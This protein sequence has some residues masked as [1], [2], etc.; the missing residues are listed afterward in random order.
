MTRWHRPIIVILVVLFAVFPGRA[1]AQGPIA[2]KEGPSVFSDR[3]REVWEQVVRQGARDNPLMRS[4]GIIIEPGRGVIDPYIEF[5]PMD[6]NVHVGQDLI[7][8]VA[9]VAEA[10]AVVFGNYGP[11]TLDKK[12]ALGQYLMA[13]TKTLADDSSTRPLPGPAVFDFFKL[14]KKEA[15]GVVSNDEFLKIS[16]YN[17]R[18][19]LTFILS[20]EFAHFALNHQLT[21]YSPG[22]FEFYEQETAADRLGLRITGEIAEDNVLGAALPL[23]FE[24]GYYSQKKSVTLPEL[25]ELCQR[26]IA[27]AIPDMENFTSRLRSDP[28]VRAEMHKRGIDIGA[29]EQAANRLS[30]ME[31]E[32]VRMTR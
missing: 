12:T 16:D 17:F 30:Q 4:P 15:E 14:T 26:S 6:N 32:C 8:S 7:A 22:S 25:R 1:S 11:A 5:G 19:L 3:T 31:E 10:N 2:T 20:H 18:I 13:V 23:L 9:L 28:D 27:V 24:L 21:H 29:W